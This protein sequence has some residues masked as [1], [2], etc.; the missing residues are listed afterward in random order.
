MTETTNPL[1]DDPS[2]ATAMPEESVLADGSSELLDGAS[3]GTD[4]GPGGVPAALTGVDKR[5]DAVPP[6]PAAL[7]GDATRSTGPAEQDEQLSGS[8]TTSPAATSSSRGETAAA[9]EIPAE[10]DGR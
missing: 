9:S 2:G 1:P 10:T 7:P 3:T 6:P 5:G 8:D 4:D